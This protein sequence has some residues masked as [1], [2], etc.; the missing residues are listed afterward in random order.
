M[1]ERKQER[2]GEGGKIVLLFDCDR[3]MFGGGGQ[4][5]GILGETQVCKQ[6][7]ADES[8]KLPTRR[9]QR[10]KRECRRNREW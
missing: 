10:Q 3:A 5:L 6:L 1:K 4:M 8:E 2:G 9:R 7:G